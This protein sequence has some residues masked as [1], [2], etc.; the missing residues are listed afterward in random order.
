MVKKLKTPLTNKVSSQDVVVLATFLLGGDK[1]PIDTED[2][3]I[4][5]NE[6]A[7]GR[8]S[9]RK[10]P[11][12]INL[13]L[14]RKTLCNNAEGYQGNDRSL[15][16]GTGRKGWT[17]TR[18]GVEWVKK[19]KDEILDGNLSWSKDSARSG[20]IDSVRLRR[21]KNR[22]Q[23]LRAWNIWSVG[24]HVEESEVKEVFRMDSYSVGRIS[25][26]KVNRLI[27]LFDGDEEMTSFLKDMISLLHEEGI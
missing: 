24:E 21:E 13:E 14:V 19:N 3:A 4:K 1:E 10:D 18:E 7:P 26:L 17:L 15:L 9:W 22:I 8:F 11:N 23:G 5:A 20:S 27:D 16:A 6:M 2:V 12:Q 25:D